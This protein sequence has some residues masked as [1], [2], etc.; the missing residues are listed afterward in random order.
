MHAVVNDP[1]RQIYLNDIG[2]VNVDC[3]VTSAVRIL[4]VLIESNS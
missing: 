2:L 1:V 3:V 4:E